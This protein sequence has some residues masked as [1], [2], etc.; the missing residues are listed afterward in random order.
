MRINSG[1]IS[2]LVSSLNSSLKGARINKAIFFTNSVIIFVLDKNRKLVFNLN[3]GDPYINISKNIDENS[4]FSNASSLYLRKEFSNSTINSFEQLNDDKI[5]KIKITSV[6]D[7]FQKVEKFILIELFTNRT[8][9]LVLNKENVITFVLHPTPFTYSRPLQKGLIYEMPS[10]NFSKAIEEDDIHLEDYN[11]YCLNEEDKLLKQRRKEKY[12]P[13]INFISNKIKST[14]RKISSI[15]SD[16]AKAESQISLN[17]VG[18][19]IYTNFESLKGQSSFIFNGTKYQIDATKPL[20]ITANDFY[21]KAKKAKTKLSEEAF[22]LQ[23]AEKDLNEY[24][25]LLA[26]FEISSEQGIDAFIKEHKLESL[27]NKKK[28]ESIKVTSSLPYEIKIDDVA[29]RFG[30]TSSQNDLL[31]FAIET[32]RNQLFLHLKDEHGGH[33]I[34]KKV[35]PSNKEIEIGCKLLLALAKKNS[36][37]V[38]FTLHKNIRKGSVPGQVI[39]NEYQSAYIKEVEPIYQE[40]IKKAQQIK[41]R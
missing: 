28:K 2:K 32:N 21:K 14:T 16:L 20:S 30:K 26:I 5:I 15:K 24:E 11:T 39:L 4:C 13:Y 40:E 19:Y 34:I 10:K 23:Q 36:G 35:S 27:L 33:L 3:S 22:Q 18:D 6:N 25:N 1:L 29:Y 31:T 12:K 8:N 17:E 38:Q 41:L 37:E 9:F 7:I